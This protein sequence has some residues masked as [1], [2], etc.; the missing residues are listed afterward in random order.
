MP[1][2]TFRGASHMPLGT[3]GGA[4]LAMRANT[5]RREARRTYLHVAAR[6]RE[7]RCNCFIARR[8]SLPIFRPGSG[9]A[10]RTAGP[11]GLAGVACTAPLLVVIARG[12]IALRAAAL[13][14]GLRPTIALRARALGLGTTA[15]RG[16]PLAAIAA[17]GV[18]VIVRSQGLAS[19]SLLTAGALRSLIALRLSAIRTGSGAAARFGATA[20]GALATALSAPIALLRAALARVALPRSLLSR[21]ALNRAAMAGTA[22]CGSP[23]SGVVLPRLALSRAGLVRTALTRA[24]GG[25]VVL[26]SGRIC[27]GTVVV[28]LID[29]G[30]TCTFY[31]SFVLRSCL[32]SI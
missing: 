28:F 4:A 21:G 25:A 12:A 15:I 31:R 10:A 2:V 1:E 23:L 5:A 6:L 14:A 24:L 29:H 19:G 30:I 3:C 27:L 13:L 11:A 22:R 17:A 20:I 8:T 9:L 16:L 32:R 7:A 18:F 26:T